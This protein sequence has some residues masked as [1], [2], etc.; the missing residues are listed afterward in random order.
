MSL[1]L[2]SM[3]KK[4]KT[5]RLHM[6]YAGMGT[7]ALALRNLKVPYQLTDVTEIDDHCQKLIKE[8]H[9][10][11]V[12]NKKRW[13]CHKDIMKRPHEKVGKSTVWVLTSPCQDFS[14]EGLR[15]G[16]KTRRGK[17]IKRS[18]AT[19]KWLPKKK[20]PRA[21]VF[22][23]VGTWLRHKKFRRLVKKIN[24]VLIQLK[25]KPRW[26]LLDSARHGGV[27]QT[28]V[29]SWGVA[30]HKRAKKKD[31]RWPGQIKCRFTM[32]DV[33]KRRPNGSDELW[34]LPPSRFGTKSRERKNWLVAAAQKDNF[35][36]L[37]GKW[38]RSSHAPA[39]SHCCVTHSAPNVTK[40]AALMALLGR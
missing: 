27:P 11:T 32:G 13:R 7:A 29:R 21:I 28:R 18:L 39:Q 26:K 20:R 35:A 30:I 22:E 1:S 12:K 33:V 16:T 31:F 3:V 36:S 24:K 34:K 4:N 2:D 17:L 19:L 9:K 8:M 14:T 5:V 40:G 10:I 25:Y 6:D 15:Q 38:K 23:Q 37:K